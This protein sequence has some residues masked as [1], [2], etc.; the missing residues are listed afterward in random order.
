MAVLLP[1][2][3]IG[4]II[5][6]INSTYIITLIYGQDFQSGSEI[7]KY[8]IVISVISFI[9]IN[10]GYPAYSTIDRLDIV[11]KSVILGGVIQLL[12]LGVLYLT[13][14]INGLNVVKSLLISESCVCM[15]RVFMFYRTSMAM[16]LVK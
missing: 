14:N 13:T 11:N 15:F 7:F 5:C 4:V 1:L 16:R 12:L 3:V 10:F 9:S 8:F 2:M 6:V